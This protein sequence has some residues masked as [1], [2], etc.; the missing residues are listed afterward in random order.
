MTN[1]AKVFWEQ[2]NV[3]FLITEFS[4]DLFYYCEKI[5]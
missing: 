1:K 4:S 2:L 3:Y 5:I